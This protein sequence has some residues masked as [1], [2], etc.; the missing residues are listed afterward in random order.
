M[1]HFTA[2]GAEA[3][4]CSV[5]CP[6]HRGV[7]A[8]PRRPTSNTHSHCLRGLPTWSARTGG[9]AVEVKRILWVVLPNLQY[10]LRQLLTHPPQTPCQAV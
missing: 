5:T 2:G 9:R 6:A 7:G 8:A 3:Q 10:H 1:P 4:R